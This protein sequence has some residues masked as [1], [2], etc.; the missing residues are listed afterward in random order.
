MGCG[1]HRGERAHRAPAPS[2]P[3]PSRSIA[4]VE[5]LIAEVLPHAEIR[6]VTPLSIDTGPSG[7]TAKR[8][9][10]GVPLRLEVDERGRRRTL[11]LHFARADEFGHDRR[12]DRAQQMLLAWDTFGEIPRHAP[13][14]DVGA[15]AGGRLVSLRD[16]GEFWLLTEWAPGVEYASDLRRVA[17]AGVA[18]EADRRRVD[19]LCDYLVAL[20]AGPGPADPRAYRRA[21]RDLVGH[22]EGVFGIVDAYGEDVAEAP[23]SRLRAIEAGCVDW[24]HRLAGLGHRLRRTHGDFHPFNVVF[25]RDELWVLDASRGGVGEPADDVTCLAINFLF[26]ALGRGDLGGGL[27][28]LWHRFWTRYLDASGDRELLAVAA[29]FLAWRALVLACPRWYPDLSAPSRD[30]L[31]GLVER[32]LAAPAFD[33]AMADEVFR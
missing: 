29:P 7:G 21:V 22:G 12:S 15:V 26:F 17:E 31:L 11:V 32:A 1:A 9:G 33:P 3:G 16:A 27:R 30:R 24:R 10:Y 18:T 20:H 19:A 28:S 23:R 25:D 2:S 13:A 4:D 8:G 5:R 6:S 14:I